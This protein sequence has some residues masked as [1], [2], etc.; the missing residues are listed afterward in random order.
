MDGGEEPAPGSEAGDFAACVVLFFAASAA[1][2]GRRGAGDKAV[3]RFRHADRRDTILLP[4]AIVAAISPWIGRR[5][6]MPGRR[7]LLL[8]GWATGSVPGLTLR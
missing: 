1:W 2:T 7:P 8:V 3:A 4:Q 6:E 5:A